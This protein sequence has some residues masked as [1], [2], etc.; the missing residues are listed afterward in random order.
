MSV[1]VRYLAAQKGSWIP[2]LGSSHFS[3]C[4]CSHCA[5]VHANTVHWTSL[6]KPPLKSR[7]RIG[8]RVL[9]GADKLNGVVK[10]IGDLN[11]SHT[12]DPIYVG[13]KLDDPGIYIYSVIPLSGHLNNRVYSYYTC[14]HTVGEHDGVFDG[15]RFFSCP[16]KHGLII[17]ANE[18]YQLKNK[19]KF[20]IT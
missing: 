3:H 1:C 20:I 2:G 5:A 4:R 11:S 7:T 8:Q 6:R 14:T 10:Y 13:V 15:K 9:V 19:V 17:P 16:E 12:N 18:V